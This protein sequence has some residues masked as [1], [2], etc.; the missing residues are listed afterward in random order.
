[1]HGALEP[2]RTID[3][4]LARVEFVLGKA[5]SAEETARVLAGAGFGVAPGKGVVSCAVPHFR[6]DVVREIDV[7]EEIARIHGIDRFEVAPRIEVPLEVDHPVAWAARERAMARIGETLTGAGFFETVTFSF[8]AER[9]AAAFIPAGMRPLKV[10][11]ARRRDTPYLRPSIVPSLMACRR[12]NQDGKVV[13]AGGVRLFETGAV[14]ADRDLG[15]G[16]GR[17]TVERRS[18]ALLADAGPRHEDHQ[19]AVRTMR[20]AIERLARDLGGRA[21]V[22]AFEPTEGGPV[23]AQGG[24]FA[25]I[26]LGGV[27]VGWMGVPAP[28][29]VAPWGLD[30]PVV[31][32]EL[33]LAALIG[34]WPPKDR[35]EAMPAFPSI[36]RDLSVV[37]EESVPW[38]R[39]HGVIDGLAVPRLEGAEYVGT[40]RGKQVGAGKKSVTVRLRFRDPARTLRHEE[41]DGEVARVVSALAASV[42]AALRQ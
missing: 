10:D 33:D 22:V 20:G 30:E 17:E 34:V 7:I 36:E 25:R 29:A 35:V 26:A 19:Q 42:G 13:R 4:R 28:S 6:P 5:I 12:A 14:F 27:D 1:V 32:A 2:T 38:K 37:V 31:V 8:V 21:L 23:F 24:S 40:F 39:L 41:V 3:V 11:E 9:D 15:P 18:L 16:R